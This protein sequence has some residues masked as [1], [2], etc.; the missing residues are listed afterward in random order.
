MH[1][2]AQCVLE[3][4]GFLIVAGGLFDLFAPRLPGNLLAIC[5]GNST[6]ERLVRELLRA[7]GGA[8]SAIGSSVLAIAL[9]GHLDRFRLLI[10]LV[11]VLPSEGI[12]A[13]GMYRVGSPWQFPAAFA[14]LA[15]V[16]VAAAWLS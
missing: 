14:L 9:C 10:V 15:L 2:A 5:S 3:L 16:G 12:N 11:M 8:L 1:T 6:A 13:L 4:A 7:L